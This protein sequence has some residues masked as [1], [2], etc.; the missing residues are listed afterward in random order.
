M[1]LHCY[2]MHLHHSSFISAFQ[3]WNG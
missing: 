2:L 3:R 1:R